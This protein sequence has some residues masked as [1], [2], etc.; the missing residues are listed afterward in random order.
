[1]YRIAHK[2]S[3]QTRASLFRRVH[4]MVAPYDRHCI[5]A[6]CI[7]KRS[8]IKMMCVCVCVFVYFLLFFSLVFS[9]PLP[10]VSRFDS[11]DVTKRRERKMRLWKNFNGAKVML[12]RR[13]ER[14][15]RG[16][17]FLGA[18]VFAAA[19]LESV[20]PGQKSSS[21]K[22]VVV[23]FPKL[24]VYSACSPPPHHHRRTKTTATTQTTRTPGNCSTK[25]TDRTFSETDTICGNRSNEI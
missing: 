4:A 12:G 21:A 11:R 14:R 5:C 25:T 23:V 3:A 15:R 17:C 8:F 7:S 19:A 20:L 10:C 18:V 1:M 2:T 22:E 9:T 24:G 6:R 16:I 13:R